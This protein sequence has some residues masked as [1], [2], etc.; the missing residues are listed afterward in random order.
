MPR[1]EPTLRYLGKD[2]FDDFQNVDIIVKLDSLT[3]QHSPPGFTFKKLHD[4]V[5]YY[6]LCFDITS[7]IPTVFESITVDKDLNVSLSYK[8][9]HIS[10]PEWFYSGFNC[11]LTNSSSMLEKFS[12][13]MRN[14]AND[15]NSILTELN[16][17][18]Y[19]SQ[20]RPPYSASI[21]RY[22]LILHHTSAQSYKLLLA[23]ISPL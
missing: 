13:H 21:I 6:K 9:Y 17:N 14:R 4:S 5:V 10:L 15:V 8:G 22:V 2:E 18:R 11:K 16:K 19:Y 20:G 3:E 12:S 1:K 23:F 7:G